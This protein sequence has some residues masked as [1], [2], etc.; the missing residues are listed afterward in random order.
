MQPVNETQVAIIDEMPV[1]HVQLE[2]GRQVEDALH[3]GLAHEVTAV[4]DEHA[5]P[6]E[7][8]SVLDLHAWTRTILKP[9][10]PQRLPR[11]ERARR[12]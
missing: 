11:V 6:A 3:R 1:Q 9:Q 10:L 7:L 12:S 2:H 4:V 8:R 5:T